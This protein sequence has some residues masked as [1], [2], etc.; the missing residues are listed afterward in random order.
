MSIVTMKRK[1]NAIHSNVSKNGFNLHGTL[2][3]PPPTIIR[4]PTYTRMKGTASAGVGTG[5][6]CRV[7]GIHSRECKNAY[8][9]HIQITGPGT[10]QT[11]PNR[12]TMSS[13]P[14]LES[15]TR[16]YVSSPYTI[17]VSPPSK[18]YEDYIQET[19][20]KVMQCTPLV[21]EET[22][23]GV[24]VCLTTKQ[25]NKHIVSYDNYMLKLKSKCV[26]PELPVK[27][28]HTNTLIGSE[29]MGIVYY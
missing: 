29:V 12:S 20:Q 15:R 22:K 2:R 28:W 27:V 5:S 19:N 11:E 14:F 1:S 17:A 13:V 21:G 25:T 9:I 23:Q 10:I 18:S 7:T 16:K 6:K 24:C 26:E 4:T 8:P 3:Q